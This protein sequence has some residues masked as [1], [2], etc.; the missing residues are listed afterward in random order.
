MARLLLQK[1]GKMLGNDGLGHFLHTSSVMA[2][3]YI[4]VQSRADDT[5]VLI[6]L[7]K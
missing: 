4:S 6:L 7:C 3:H 1:K 5:E 2:V